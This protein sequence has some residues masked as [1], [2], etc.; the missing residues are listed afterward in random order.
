MRDEADS[1]ELVNVYCA[2][3]SSL[4]F[5][6]NYLI[7]LPGNCPRSHDATASESLLEASRRKQLPDCPMGINFIMYRIVLCTSLLVIWIEWW[8][9]WQKE[10]GLKRN[11]RLAIT[12]V[13]CCF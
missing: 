4:Y 6:L 2:P 5:K 7:I 1:E 9:L 10:A 8:P 12:F 3:P 13:H 11:Q